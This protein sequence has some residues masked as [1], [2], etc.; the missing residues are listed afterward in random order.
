MKPPRP[1]S[2]EELRAIVEQAV[3]ALPY[4]RLDSMASEG[5]DHPDETWAPQDVEAW[6]LDEGATPE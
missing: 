4:I 1:L 6:E 5:L 3:D 2:R